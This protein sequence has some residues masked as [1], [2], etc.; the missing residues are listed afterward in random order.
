[1]QQ[2]AVP[3]IFQT[4]L[5]VPRYGPVRRGEW[6][7]SVT[8][9]C[10]ST[11]YWT[12]AVYLCGMA[13]LARG[14]D[15]WMSLA[16]FEVESQETGIRAAAG[17]VLIF[18]LGMGWAAAATAFQ[19]AVTAVTV[20]ERDPDLIDLHAELDLFSQLPEAARAKLRL[21]EGDA[22]TFVPE[23]A[24]DLLMPDIWLPLISDGRI[25]EVR[26]MQGNVQ[27]RAVYFWG[28]EL[29]IARHAVADGR[30]PDDAGIAA[31]VAASGLPLI[32]PGI[33]G[34]AEKVVGVAR[35]WMKNHWLPGSVAPW[36]V[37]ARGVAASPSA[38]V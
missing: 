4:D 38:P 31:T 6:E 27:A 29:E 2:Q 32:G 16:P 7:L 13:G 12:D 15:C 3:N 10:L 21:V 18:G 30:A 23:R 34:Y 33:P 9:M 5:F 25:N 11:G 22:F 20:V 24:V 26:R 35:R 8:P 37:T 36:P 1:M 14:D 28:Q 17:H 19:P